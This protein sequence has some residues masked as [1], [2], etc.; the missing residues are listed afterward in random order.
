MLDIT[1]DINVCREY[2]ITTA[3]QVISA[4]QAGKVAAL[5][6]A[7]ALL[8]SARRVLTCSYSS[9]VLEAFLMARQEGIELEVIVARSQMSPN[10]LAYGELMA[11]KLRTNGLNAG[12]VDDGFIPQV[13]DGHEIILL[14][15]D[16]IMPDGSI[17]NGFP[18]RF[19]AEE[20]RKHPNVRVYS[21]A[22][23][24]KINLEKTP[25]RERGFDLLPAGLI[26]GIVSEFG[27]LDN[28]ALM[29][30]SN[31]WRTDHAW[32]ASVLKLPE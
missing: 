27:I 18:S 30:R 7:M 12:I 5:K 16:A 11:E 15:S 32:A 1:A 17:V 28:S 19:L 31:K 23:T 13:F 2:T 24:C 10:D 20:G 22:E 4:W 21:I 14:G 26:T 29:E 6:Q 8:K 25:Q 3:N 9:T